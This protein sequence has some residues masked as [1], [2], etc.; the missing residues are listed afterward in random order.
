MEL[1]IFILDPLCWCYTVVW[2]EWLVDIS[3]AI[4]ARVNLISDHVQS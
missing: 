1:L 2:I 4:F 3:G